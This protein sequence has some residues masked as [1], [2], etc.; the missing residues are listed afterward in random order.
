MIAPTPA[1]MPILAASPRMPSLSSAWVTDSV[2]SCVRPFAVNWVNF[3]TRLPRRS[4]RE[5]RSTATT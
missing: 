2:T 3:S 5:A 4:V 1:P